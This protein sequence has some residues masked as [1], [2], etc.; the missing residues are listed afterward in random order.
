MIR[1]YFDPTT[2]FQGGSIFSN[3]LKGF[4]KERSE[5]NKQ[6]MELSLAQADPEFLQRQIRIITEN[7]GELQKIKAKALAPGGGG[8]TDTQKFVQRL[9]IGDQ[10]ALRDQRLELLKQGGQ[11]QSA[12][13]SADS[14]ISKA[15][16]N[17]KSNPADLQREISSM[18]GRVAG[19]PLELEAFKIALAERK[20]S[21]PQ[22]FGQV[23]LDALGLKTGQVRSQ[24]TR[25]PELG[26]GR[27]IQE[28]VDIVDSYGANP[29]SSGSQ[30][31]I[32]SLD[33]QIA[34]YEEKLGSYETKLDDLL[35]G[36]STGVFD[37]FSRNYML[38]N[39]F[40]QMSRQQG[41]V[42]ALAA[43][44]E[45]SSKLDFTKPFEPNVETRFRDPVIPAKPGEDFA[46]D[47]FEGGVFTD[48]YE[49]NIDALVQRKALGLDPD[50]E[51]LLLQMGDVDPTIQR[52]QKDIEFSFAAPEEEEELPEGGQASVAQQNLDQFLEE[53]GRDPLALVSRIDDDSALQAYAQP[54]TVVS[55][56]LFELQ[57]QDQDDPRL[58]GL[59]TGIG[60]VPSGEP[61]A[62]SMNPNVPVQTPRNPLTAAVRE[63]N[64]FSAEPLQQYVDTGEIIL[65][66]SNDGTEITY[67]PNTPAARDELL[68]QTR[69]N[70]GL[71]E[72]EQGVMQ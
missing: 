43:A 47:D 5:M 16:K 52:K 55:P 24:F 68:R 23:D 41:Q 28:F 67:T 40:I 31:F 13:T 44:I 6:L 59:G 51:Y 25:R 72:F 30:A 56:A 36:G 26:T 10:K 64:L 4:V 57:R 22:L 42:D 11:K 33:A 1:P 29:Q 2:E 7:I 35:E 19:D 63:S 34:K 50:E 45:E 20:A 53:T 48:Y 37:D 39:P 14:L 38:D 46:P 3:Y 9:L 66:L 62:T 60:G 69:R 32:D 15:V 12:L 54:R 18:S 49:E 61:L 58:A 71:V 27:S 70:V 8:L 65:G 21:D 17:A